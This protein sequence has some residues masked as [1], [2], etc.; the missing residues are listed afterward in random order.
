MLSYHAKLSR[1]S[2]WD[3][4]IVKEGQD[5]CRRLQCC[6]LRVLVP[7]LCRPQSS[8]M[9]FIINYHT[10]CRRV[11]TVYLKWARKTGR[12]K[13]MLPNTPTSRTKIRLILPK[14]TSLNLIQRKM[15]MRSVVIRT[16]L[17]WVQ[18]GHSMGYPTTTCLRLPIESW[19]RLWALLEVS[20]KILQD[21]NIQRRWKKRIR[22]LKF[23]MTSRAKGRKT[24]LKW[25]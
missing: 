17:I 23:W 11:K 15:C 5:H 3:V 21:K 25:R 19:N 7:P 2:W 12:M 22:V 16:G 13:S 8:L 14:L 4:S 1:D 20:E 6:P 24:F 10:N 9:A 18:K